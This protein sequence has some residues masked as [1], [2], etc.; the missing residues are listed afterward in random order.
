MTDINAVVEH[1]ITLRDHK[2][3]LDAEHK[4]RV[5]EIDAQMKNAE[6]FLL[7]HMNDTNQKNAGFLAGTVII[8]EKIMPGFED[9]S[10]A[11]QFIKETDN[12]DLL[13][14]RLSSTAVKEYMGAHNGELPPGVKIA[15]ERTV[16]IRRK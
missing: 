15:V 1:Y 2:A 10:K 6:G 3:K 4:A 14:V 9:K 5:A 13:S 12:M 8:G 16:S 7:G 11:M